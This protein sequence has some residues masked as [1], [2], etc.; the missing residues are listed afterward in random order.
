MY[1]DDSSHLCIFLIHY[2]NISIDNIRINGNC[3]VIEFRWRSGA[4]LQYGSRQ[5]K[6]LHPSGEE[7][8]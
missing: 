6:S 7:S 1:K 4:T 8:T 2:A 3:I 5:S